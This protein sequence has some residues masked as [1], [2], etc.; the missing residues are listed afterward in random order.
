M[1]EDHIEVFIPWLLISYIEDNAKSYVDLTDGALVLNSLLHISPR[2]HNAF[3]SR[4]VLSFQCVWNTLA[5]VNF[6][7]LEKNKS[8]LSRAKISKN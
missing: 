4:P 7:W 5:G 1:F 3:F 8:G 2:Q 6:D